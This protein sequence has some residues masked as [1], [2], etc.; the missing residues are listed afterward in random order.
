MPA[1][2]ASA[3]LFFTVIRKPL[4][5]LGCLQL[6]PLKYPADDSHKQESAR[7]PEG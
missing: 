6:A 2:V 3:I 1:I 7:H 5:R 4:M